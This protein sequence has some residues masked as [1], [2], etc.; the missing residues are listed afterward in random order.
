MPK[1]SPEHIQVV[2][3]EA[4]QAIDHAQALRQKV[5]EQLRTADSTHVEPIR[6]TPKP[7]RRKRA[8]VQPGD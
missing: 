1:L 5:D 6:L 4:D 7:D 2:L 3:R 8:R